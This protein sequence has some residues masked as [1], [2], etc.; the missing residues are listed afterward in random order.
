M[1][2]HSPRS[3]PRQVAWRALAAGGGPRK[4][5]R[6]GPVAAVCQSCQPNVSHLKL[7]NAI[8][9]LFAHVPARRSP[10]LFW[11]PH[12]GEQRALCGS[13]CFYPNLSRYAANRAQTVQSEPNGV[14]SSQQL[15]GEPERNHPFAKPSQRLVRILG[16]TALLNTFPRN[17]RHLS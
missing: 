9:L 10:A 8:G 16:G 7:E 2:R 11:S 3:L 13:C 1:W 12:G 5:E 4:C 6:R 17:R 14:Y 15:R